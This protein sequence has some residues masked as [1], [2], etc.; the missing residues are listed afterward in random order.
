MSDPFTHAWELRNRE[1]TIAALRQQLAAAE[2]RFAEL[3]EQHDLSIRPCVLCGEDCNPW[4]SD[5]HGM[6]GPWMT[7]DEPGVVKRAHFDCVARRIAT[8]T[9]ALRLLPRD[10]SK[11]MRTGISYN[12]AMSILA[13]AGE[14]ASDEKA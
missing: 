12:Q 10:V 4:M 11:L 7:A 1:Q 3:T 8:L 2:Q 13:L 6:Y 9:A 5:H 14:G